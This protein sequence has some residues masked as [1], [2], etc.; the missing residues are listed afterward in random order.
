MHTVA[1]NSTDVVRRCLKLTG[2]VKDD[3]RVL[4][5]LTNVPV[6]DIHKYLEAASEIPFYR[7][8]IKLTSKQVKKLETFKE[9]KH[10]PCGFELLPSKDLEDLFLDITDERLNLC[11]LYKDGKRE[12]IDIDE[13]D[14]Q[15][16]IDAS[17]AYQIGVVDDNQ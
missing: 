11:L 9:T 15:E 8:F 2:N 6:K 5:H 7:R 4:R 13:F 12:I 14:I 3:T 10:F 16:Y 1:G 17:D